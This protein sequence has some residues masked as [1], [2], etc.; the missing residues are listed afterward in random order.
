MAT[1]GE[2]DDIKCDAEDNA[3]AKISSILYGH[4][5]VVNSNTV[6]SKEHRAKLREV[7]AKNASNVQMISVY[8]SSSMLG[9]PSLRVRFI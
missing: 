6:A 1:L 2:K 5:N 7:G 8:P 4:S 3:S 9:Y